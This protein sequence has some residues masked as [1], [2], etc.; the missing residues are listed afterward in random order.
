LPQH[1]SAT[2]SIATSATPRSSGSSQLERC[3]AGLLEARERREI[4][5]H[6]RHRARGAFSSAAGSFAERARHRRAAAVG[7]SVTSAAA[8]PT[9]TDSPS[10]VGHRP[11]AACM[12]KSTRR[13]EP[14]DRL[15]HAGAE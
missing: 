2:N 5:V 13:G 3:L 12:T 1:P 7:A 11:A 15:H 10:A 6:R 8:V 9:G 14:V 4:D